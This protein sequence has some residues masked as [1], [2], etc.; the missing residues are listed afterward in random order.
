MSR[1]ITFFLAGT[2]GDVQPLLAIARS[3]ER[4]GAIPV[5]ATHRCFEPLVKEAGLRF[6]ALPGD[7]PAA[8]ATD[9]GRRYMSAGRNTLRWAA[10]FNEILV[11]FWAPMLES[12]VALTAQSDAIVVSSLTRPAA[13][14]A[15][16]RGIPYA[17]AYLGPNYATRR[18][19]H[20]L[21]PQ[22]PLGGLY[23]RASHLLVPLV[24]L[25]RSSSSRV[26]RAW[27]A[28]HAL[29]KKP[30]PPRATVFGFSPLV[31]PPPEKSD[32][33]H[34]TGYWFLDGDADARLPREVEALVAEEGRPKVAVSLSSIKADARTTA[35]L[36]GA[37][38][39]ASSRLRTRTLVIS[40]W[41]ELSRAAGE[42][43][44]VTGAIPHERV[45][46][47]VDVVVHH[48]GAGS[49]AS[50]LRAGV[51]SVVV[52]FCADQYFWADRLHRLGVAPAPVPARTITPAKLGE[53]I[54]AALEDRAMRARARTLGAAIASEGGV[55]RAARVLVE[56]TAVA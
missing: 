36:S 16:A 33:A 41:T 5:V 55:E 12:F 9:V 54:G 40:G 24:L 39:G 46:P 25:P 3:V 28:R 32:G 18:F 14:A 29:P 34:V 10:A 8:F 13:L 6:E 31:V 26:T 19:A 50:A 11:G 4:L 1:R 45:F 23:N 2:R 47:R 51:P 38:A 35:R 48:G 52:P 44:V 7:I 20:R 21:A 37:L 49:A 43:T 56:A 30:A 17:G 27:L 15:T 22:L 53:A 42:D